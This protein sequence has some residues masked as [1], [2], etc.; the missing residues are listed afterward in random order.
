MPTGV[1]DLEGLPPDLLRDVLLHVVAQSVGRDRTESLLAAGKAVDPREREH[2][3]GAQLLPRADRAPRAVDALEDLDR[4]RR[5]GHVGAT[6][7]ARADHPL[8]ARRLV[9]LLADAALQEKDLVEAALGGAHLDAARELV[10]FGPPSLDAAEFVDPDAGRRMQHD[11]GCGSDA[12]DD[13]A[14]DDGRGVFGLL[15]D[16][17]R[18]VPWLVTLVRL[19]F[20]AFRNLTK[21]NLSDP[22]TRSRVSGRRTDRP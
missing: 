19:R 3:R 9:L 10:T 22:T 1:G 6:P 4:L 2:Q 11:G 7:H 16:P 20:V 13:P 12:A 14:D 5:R 18:G 15:P 8:G 17:D 21:P